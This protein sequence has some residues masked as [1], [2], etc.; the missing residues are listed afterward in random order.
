MRVKNKNLRLRGRHGRS[1]KIRGHD[2]VTFDRHRQ[3]E[4]VVVIGVFADDV[5]AAGRGDDETGRT[6]KFFLKFNGDVRGEF[7]KVHANKTA[8][9][10]IILRR[11][12][13]NVARAKL[14]IFFPA[15]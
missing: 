14:R 6:V 7:W 1:G 4:A 11:R 15:R 3:E 10:K 12:E 8:P 2:R 5:D 13:S 9:E